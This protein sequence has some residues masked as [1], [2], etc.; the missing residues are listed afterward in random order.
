MVAAIAAKATAKEIDKTVIIK[1][2]CAFCNRRAIDI[3]SMDDLNF[4]SIKRDIP[5]YA[6]KLVSLPIC[7]MHFWKY[8][9]HPHTRKP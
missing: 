5:K 8:V 9:T 2:T 4:V 7:D 1:K 3:I 6:R